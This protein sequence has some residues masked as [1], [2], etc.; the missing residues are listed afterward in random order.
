MVHVNANH[1][2]AGHQTEMKEGFPPKDLRET[3]ACH[4]R[5]YFASEQN[6]INRHAN[7]L[8]VRHWTACP[9]LLRHRKGSSC[10]HE[11]AVKTHCDVSDAQ[12]GMTPQDKEVQ[13]L[14]FIAAL[15][16]QLCEQKH[17][18]IMC[19][20]NKDFKPEKNTPVLVAS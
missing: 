1:Q 4:K 20:R 2:A 15:H 6:E 3:Q 13:V 10:S 8:R 18:E 17:I 16:R 7:G 14:S 11:R 5:R 19:V 9:L 12:H